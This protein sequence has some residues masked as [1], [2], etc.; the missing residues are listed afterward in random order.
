MG[1]RDLQFSRD[2][3]HQAPRRIGKHPESLFGCPG[4]LHGGTL[5]SRWIFHVCSKN[6]GLLPLPPDPDT[7]IHPLTCSY[8]SLDA[9]M[10]AHVDMRAHADMC[11]CTGAHTQA[12]ARP[13]TDSG[14][15]VCPGTHPPSSIP[16]ME[17]CNIFLLNVA[18]VVP[19]SS[20]PR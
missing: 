7:N 6:A 9:D 3:M 20:S 13:E 11:A 10:H 1:D 18:F 5:G 17:C 2:Q 14:V 4:P 12:P 15:F 19:F 8:M 16:L